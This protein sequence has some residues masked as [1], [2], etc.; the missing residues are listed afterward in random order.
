M[1]VGVAV[2][3]GLASIEEFAAMGHSFVERG[4]SKV[5]PFMLTRILGNMPAGQISIRG[6]FKVMKIDF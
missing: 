2:G 3:T 4:Y 5:S 1:C 6:T